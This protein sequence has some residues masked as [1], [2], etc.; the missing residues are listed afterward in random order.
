[1]AA[2]SQT[3]TKTTSG[4]VYD[5]TGADVGSGDGAGTLTLTADV[6]I[7]NL[8]MTEDE[9]ITITEGVTVKVPSGK[10]F[11][12]RCNPAGGFIGT[13][14]TIGTPSEPVVLTSAQAS[15]SPGDWVGINYLRGDTAHP[16]VYPTAE[17]TYTTIEYPQTCVLSQSGSGFVPNLL[18]A[19][20]CTFQRWSTA[21]ISHQAGMGA[22]CPWKI[23][24]C[25]FIECSA[26]A[27]TNPVIFVSTGGLP[28]SVIQY[29]RVDVDHC[30]FLTY[31][32]YNS[33]D[34]F[35]FNV[36]NKSVGSLTNSVIYHTNSGSK[37]G[38]I[39]NIGVTAS[40]FDS[41]HNFY[42]TPDAGGNEEY[43]PASSDQNVDPQYTNATCTTADLS[44]NGEARET[45]TD[46][47]LYQADSSNWYVGAVLP[48]NLPSGNTPD[49]EGT[50]GVWAGRKQRVYEL[51]FGE[52]AGIARARALRLSVSSD[53]TSGEKIL[54]GVLLRMH[55]ERLK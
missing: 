25:Q 26:D 29:A 28:T 13:L 27:A 4:T 31:H 33:D 30:S 47:Y 5:T 39:L 40:T 34:I 23:N 9:T 49:P 11:S 10:K 15:P 1:M 45:D 52:D 32:N 51:T 12:I 54:A 2:G 44:P 22:Y 6:Q 46:P 17:L 42:W 35:L 8:A 24:Y 3:W 16:N 37:E 36:G 7:G 41:H 21:A 20:Y 53:D 19:N 18:V 50:A 48:Y 38:N 43:T 14:R 55:P